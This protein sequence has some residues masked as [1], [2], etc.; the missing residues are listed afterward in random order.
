[1]IFS[2]DILLENGKDFRLN[3]EENPAINLADL[4]IQ[5]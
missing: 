3:Q 1:M 4:I 2:S 5:K